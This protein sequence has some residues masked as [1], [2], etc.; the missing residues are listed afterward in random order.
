LDKYNEKNHSISP[1]PEG[2]RIQNMIL[3]PEKNTTLSLEENRT[4]LLEKNT[5]LS[6]E[7]NRTLLPEKNTTLS[8]S[9]NTHIT[10]KKKIDPKY[11][12][13]P[14][15]KHLK[16]MGGKKGNPIYIRIFKSEAV[17][18]IWMKVKDDYVHFEDY[19]I[20]AYSGDL[21]PKIKEGDRQSPEGFYRVYKNN[22]NPYSRYH[23]SFNLG[24]PNPYDRARHRTGS[25][26]MVHGDCR[27]VGCYAMTDT[28][29]ED[30]YGLVK[31]ALKA[32]QN[33]VPVHIFPF[34][35]ND[36]TMAKYSNHTWYDFWVKLKEGYDY[37]EA[38]RRPPYVDIDNGDYVV[39]EAKE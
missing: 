16:A 6:L 11:I 13:I 26:L 8:S 34:R 29:I 30:I 24:Y 17:L 14:L 22:L 19:P 5:T 15:K 3:S 10:V 2:N 7:E 23:L 27:S 9:K 33:Y 37:F 12:H 31:A 25:Y 28:Q 38:E 1:S 32:G 4:L 35:M 20:C 18:E 39:L 36:E 21:G